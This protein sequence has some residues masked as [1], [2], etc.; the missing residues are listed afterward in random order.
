MNGQQQIIFEHIAE[1]RQFQ[2]IKH[3]LF[4]KEDRLAILIEEVGEVGKAINEHDRIE[5][6]KELIQVAA[7][8]V[9]WLERIDAEAIGEMQNMNESGISPTAEEI[10]LYRAVIHRRTL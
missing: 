3:P 9:R 7:V 1:E 4:P 5:L 8:A 6:R 2:N 10:E